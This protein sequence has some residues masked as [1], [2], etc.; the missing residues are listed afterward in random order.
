M[1]PMEFWLV[2]NLWKFL[3]FKEVVEFLSIFLFI[4]RSKIAIV[5]IFGASIKYS[6]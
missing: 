6:V 2:A 1:S 3:V 5:C 4:G